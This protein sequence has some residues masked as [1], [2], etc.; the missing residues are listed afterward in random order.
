MCDD[1]R[2]VL[3]LTQP[4]A[5]ANQKLDRILLGSFDYFTGVDPES[6]RVVADFPINNIQP[7]E[8]L[9]NHFA[10][11]STGVW[12]LKFDEPILQLQQGVLVV[13]VKDRAGNVTRIERNFSVGHPV[14][15]Q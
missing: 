12:E 9:W 1:K 15:Q 3:T 4:H 2:P 13:S 10:R 5:G 8:N 11:K 14:E 6:L 7:G